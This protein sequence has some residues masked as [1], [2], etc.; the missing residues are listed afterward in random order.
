MR[1]RIWALAAVSAVAG[2]YVWG[3]NSDGELAAHWALVTTMDCTRTGDAQ[4][5]AFDSWDRLTPRPHIY[6]LSQCMPA[7][8]EDKATLVPVFDATFDG[9]PLFSG[10]LFRTT[11]IAAVQDMQAVAWVNADILLAQDVGRTVA[12]ALRQ[13]RMPWMI[14]GSRHNIP[15]SRLYRRC[16]TPSDLALFIRREGTPHTGGGIDLFV[17]NMPH[18][19]VVRAPLP[20]FIRT[21]NIWDNWWATEAATTRLVVDAA[22]TMTIGHIEHR[23]YDTSGRHVMPETIRGERRSPWSSAQSMWK[24]WHN[25]HNRAV[26]LRFQ[27]GYTTGIGTPNLLPVHAIKNGGGVQFQIVGAGTQRQTVAGQKMAIEYAG[28]LHK[29]P[30]EPSKISTAQRTDGVSARF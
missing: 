7:F 30:P 27:R 9:L 15:A 11:V 3:S 2:L 21:A 12:H 16:D 14:V 25:Y 26:A 17:W 18:R 28:N 1:T 5:A 4:R 8:M 19:P 20:P 13:Q 22:G 23:R 10:M 24:D 29:F 6:V